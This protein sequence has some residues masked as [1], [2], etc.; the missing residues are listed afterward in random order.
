M[1]TLTRKQITEILISQDCT[2]CPYDPACSGERQC[3]VKLQAAAMLNVDLINLRSLNSQIEATK[4][5]APV[6]PRKR[7]PIEIEWHDQHGEVCKVLLHGHM[8]WN[9]G[10]FL[11]TRIR[12]ELSCKPYKK[13]FFCD[14][15]F[16]LAEVP[17][18]I[19]VRGIGNLFAC[20]KC[21]DKVKGDGR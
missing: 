20:T 5:A 17:V 13:C 16:E 6:K 11:A 7:T 3:T 12:A 21:Y 8:P 14:H 1:K 10:H 15:T 4:K 19:S 18:G 2:K 9:M